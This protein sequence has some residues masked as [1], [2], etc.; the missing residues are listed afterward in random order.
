MKTGIGKSES[1]Y[2][3][4][5]AFQVSSDAINIKEH[6]EYLMKVRDKIDPV[7]QNHLAPFTVIHFINCLL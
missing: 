7:K 3:V 6:E 2:V 4:I 5:K 1:G